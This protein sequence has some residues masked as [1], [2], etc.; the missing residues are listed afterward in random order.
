MSEVAWP[1]LSPGLFVR[2]CQLERKRRAAL[3]RS[4]KLNQTRPE[5]HF[6]FQTAAPGSGLDKQTNISREKL[7]LVSFS[8]SIAWVFPGK[9]LRKTASA[10]HSR[11]NSREMTV[12]D[13]FGRGPA[14]G[15][16][17]VLGPRPSV[18]RTLFSFLF[19]RPKVGRTESRQ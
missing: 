13:W 4:T 18:G 2:G 12:C 7:R 19:I 11:V 5:V 17:F 6:P 16:S 1:G 9:C 3:G 15:W 14:F 8:F 10:K